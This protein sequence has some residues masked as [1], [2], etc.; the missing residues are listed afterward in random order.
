MRTG[1]D[2]AWEIFA[3]AAFFALIPG[4]SRLCLCESAAFLAALQFLLTAAAGVRGKSQ[5]LSRRWNGN[6]VGG[7]GADGVGGS[8][9]V[10]LCEE[11]RLFP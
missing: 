6:G 3:D 8:I 5:P 2:R 1:G 4:E 10:G 7:T 9:S 11:E